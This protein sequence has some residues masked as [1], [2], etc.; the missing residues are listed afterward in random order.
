MVLKKKL[1]VLIGCQCCGGT[2]VFLLS[3]VTL[4]G[5]GTRYG[6][7]M[8]F[9]WSCQAYIVPSQ[10]GT[11]EPLVR[12]H[13]DKGTFP[14]R[15]KSAEGLPHSG[16]GDSDAEQVDNAPGHPHHEAHHHEV[17]ERRLHDLPHFLLTPKN[18][19]G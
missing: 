12:I 18:K 16:E 19:H 3:S 6:C 10:R 1:N 7:I 5:L 8:G 9:F 2:Y 4:L 11:S 14:D 13:F 15:S 17:L